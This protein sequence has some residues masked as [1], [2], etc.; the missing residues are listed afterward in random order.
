[1]SLP[2]SADRFETTLLILQATPWCNLDCS[3]CYLPN[4][5][6]RSVMGSEVAQAAV[7]F[8]EREGLNQ[9]RVLV[10]WHSGE[11]LALPPAYYREVI[12]A[13]R[14][15]QP[16]DRPFNFNLQTNGVAVSDQYCDLFC[17]FD[18]KI[19]VS[20]DGP[21]EMHDRYRRTLSGRGSHA[22]AVRGFRKL[23]ERG[24]EPSVISVITRDTLSAPHAFMDFFCD[25][26]VET[27]GLCFEE[28]VGAH[29]DSSLQRVQLDQIKAFLDV[30]Y[31]RALRHPRMTVREFRLAYRNFVSPLADVHVSL[32]FKILSVDW[33]GN[34]STFCPE[35]LGMTSQRYGDFNFG[36]VQ[37]DG[38]DDVLKSEKFRH[39]YRDIRA[40]IEACQRECRYFD[41]CGG[42]IPSTKLAENGSFDSTETS[43]CAV[44]TQALTDVVAAKYSTELEAGT[45]WSVHYKERM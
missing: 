2:L 15:E 27:L 23:Q 13:I 4:R 11:P 38:L 28:Q 39:V 12:S 31:D 35:L 10:S 9:G 5:S 42:G 17:E 6:D 45:F 22:L 21:V 3:Y 36:N 18:V 24:L 32:P 44:R 1:M 26:E 40:G 41:L 20:I 34:F 29:G 14:R 7:R 16:S 43:S 8:L 37:W 30:V 19:G 33:K 25:L